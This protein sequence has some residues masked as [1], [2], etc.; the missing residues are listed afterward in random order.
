MQARPENIAQTSGTR[1]KRERPRQVLSVLTYVS[2][3][4]ANGGVMMDISERGMAISS[5]EPIREFGSHKLRFQLPRIERA[6]ETSAELVWTSESKKNAG[7]RFSSLSVEDRLQI[8][9]WIKDE[10]F[11]EAF[12]SRAAVRTVPRRELNLSY[13]ALLGPN[14][15]TASSAT[16]SL[17]TIP[18]K[19]LADLPVEVAD[20]H[21][22]EFDRMFPSERALPVEPTMRVEKFAKLASV[23]NIETT[24]YWM[25]FPSELELAESAPDVAMDEPAGMPAPPETEDAHADPAQLA[26]A[27]PLEV[28]APDHYIEEEAIEQDV[29]IHSESSHVIASQPQRVFEADATQPLEP[30]P[31][32]AQSSSYVDLAPEVMPDVANEVAPEVVV[33][34]AALQQSLPAI[35]NEIAIPEEML[36][37]APTS[38]AEAPAEIPV[39][40]GVGLPVHDLQPV[41]EGPQFAASRLDLI[42]ISDAV[43]TPGKFSGGAISDASIESLLAIAAEEEQS[44]QRQAKPLRLVPEKKTVVAA[45]AAAAPARKMG[46]ATLPH[47]ALRSAS[48]QSA[49][50]APSAPLAAGDKK[51]GGLA[52]A[53][54]IMLLALCFAIGYSSHFRPTW[55]K[56]SAQTS[57]SLA[58]ANNFVSTP[59]KS[60]DAASPLPDSAS[61]APDP[62]Y[63]ATPLPKPAEPPPSTFFPVTAP[64]EGSAPRMVEL[65]ETTVFD[66]PKVLIRMSQFFFVP[67][68]TGP[69]WSHNLER[70]SIGEP[71]A[72]VPPAPADSLQAAVVKVRAT[73]GKDGV[74]TN[75]R[76]L[77]GPVSLIPR[78]LDAIRHWRYEPSAL[79]GKP[80][81]WQGDFTIEFRP[82]P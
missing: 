63:N 39:D 76:P 65:P 30:Q 55:T 33:Q 43:K 37:S 7:V 72:K 40:D 69:E 4:D 46:A 81:E 56:P 18:R 34:A 61:V 12:P 82:A 3:D 48:Q 80:V 14:G 66:S 8:R 22:R 57:D 2:V 45:P 32:V 26:A 25:N 53:A 75:A 67:A 59:S 24:A 49:A 54:S 78:S 19:S 27:A 70:I 9:N 74:V 62:N 44:A 64:A 5:A 60:A 36:A 21:S 1:E 58:P 13:E 10:L 47:V 51:F 15:A 23:T 20:D 16:Q 50:S 42:D 41:P 17:P 73:I 29:V 38:A 52:I 71:T 35:R 79:D 77:S 28:P 11:A 31:Q 68:Q 6:F